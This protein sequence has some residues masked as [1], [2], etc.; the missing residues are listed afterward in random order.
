[1][2]GFLSPVSFS[3][4][5][6]PLLSYILFAR[7]F[8][9]SRFFPLAFHPSLPAS[10]PPTRV[11]VCICS[12]L[13]ISLPVSLYSA[14][15]A[16]RLRQCQTRIENMY[17]YLHIV[18]RINT[19]VWLAQ[20]DACIVRACK[21]SCTHAYIRVYAR[22]RARTVLPCDSSRYI[23]PGTCPV[24]ARSHT[25]VGHPTP[26]FSDFSIRHARRKFDS[27]TARQKRFQTVVIR[28]PRIAILIPNSFILIAFRSPF[29]R[30]YQ[31]NRTRR[32]LPGVPGVPKSFVTAILRPN[33]IA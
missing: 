22:V 7:S 33:A 23:A 8:S 30:S 16:E 25:P 28:H 17:T 9:P 15:R 32:F 24:R 1:M 12:P 5:L 3:P 6:L 13:V 10:L 26:I 21:Y 2:I 31:E 4:F 19:S 11:L 14:G 29:L 27:D 18:A 20:G